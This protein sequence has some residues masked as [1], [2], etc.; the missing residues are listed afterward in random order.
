V[1]ETLDSAYRFGTMGD[2]PQTTLARV[3]DV[4]RAIPRASSATG[5]ASKSET[6]LRQA[7]YAITAAR[8]LGLVT[9]PAD[10][11][12]LTAAGRQLASTPPNSA[13][14]ATILRQAIDSSPRIARL[15][16]GLM[17]PTPPSTEDIAGHIMKEG[18]YAFSTATQRASMMLKWR[19][20]LAPKQERLE[21]PSVGNSAPASTT[22]RSPPAPP[23]GESL[24]AQ[25]E[26]TFEISA[27]RLGPL[28]T[29][30]LRI[31]PFTVFVGPQGSG[32]SL[33]AQV[34]Y[35][36]RALPELIPG[37]VAVRPRGDA[38][39]LSAESLVKGVLDKLR[40]PQRSFAI[41]ADPSAT[42]RWTAEGS[43]LRLGFGTYSLQRRVRPD[44][45]L[46]RYVTDLIA[47][48]RELDSRAIFIPT[49]RLFYS[50]V[51]SPL[52][53]QLLSL[54]NTYIW[55][56]EWMRRATDVFETWK[57]GTPDTP[58]GR[59][60]RDRA[61]SALRGEARRWRDTWKWRF[62]RG[63]HEPGTLDLD[64]ASSG[65]RATWP[66]VL[67]AETLFSMRKRGR[68]N[69]TFTLYVEEPEIHLHPEAQVAVVEILAYLVRNGFRVVVTTHSLPV[70]YALNNLVV[71]GAV[72]GRRTSE[73]G[74]PPEAAVLSKDQI[75][76]YAL[77]DGQP[78][79]L[80]DPETGFINEQ[81]LGRVAEQ[82]SETMNRLTSRLYPVSG[83]TDK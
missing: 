75:A 50:Q 29:C 13:N 28:A 72:P 2:V 19:D 33:L 66:I 22:P 8:I 5:V 55:F 39:D 54:P 60:V 63:S 46:S 83:A 17:G 24:A 23:T 7:Q 1:E 74:L 68:L 71:A 26:E 21:L 9:G 47:N 42:I 62:S 38:K 20:L 41:F 70:L 25:R 77:G 78:T 30:T 37:E 61:R 79:D 3:L 56:S 16:P 40:S 6:P 58:R 51:R 53:P 18:D 45:H 15:A 82:L 64:M 49:E 73:S 12:K 59:W 36:F 69:D 11:L 35:F 14:E 32:K 27:G 4:V 48:F 31:R 43:Q 10:Q 44:Q 52:A 57:D 34:L 67:L 65:Q 76:A 80:V 81:E